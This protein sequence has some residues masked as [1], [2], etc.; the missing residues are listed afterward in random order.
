[1][2][3]EPSY[4]I[5]HDRDY[6]RGGGDKRE[7]SWRRRERKPRERMRRERD[8][9]ERLD[10]GPEE[11]NGGSPS[12]RTPFIIAKKDSGG[13][14]GGSDIAAKR[15]SPVVSIQRRVF[16]HA[17]SSSNSKLYTE[18]VTSYQKH[19]GSSGGEKINEATSPSPATPTAAPVPNE[20]PPTGLAALKIAPEVFPTESSSLIDGAFQWSDKIFETLLDQ[21]DFIVVGCVGMQAAG[22]STLMSMISGQPIDTI[23]KTRLVFRPQKRSD[24][25][26]CIHRTVGVD[27]YVTSGRMILLDTQPLLSPSM[28]DQYLRYDRKVPSEYST[29]EI[30]LEIQA[31]QILTFLYTVCHVVLVVQDHFTDLNLLNLLKTAEMLKP[32]TVSHAGQDGSGLGTSPEDYTEYFPY[33]VFVY[34]CCGP[35]M[36]ELH[37]LHSICETTAKIFESSRLRIRNSASVIRASLLTYT[38]L[39][40]ALTDYK[41]LNIFLLPSIQAVSSMEDDSPNASRRFRGNPILSVL[42]RQLR[43][44]LAGMPREL[45]THNVL[46]E[47]NWFHYAAR[48]WEAVKKSNLISEYHRLLT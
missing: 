7:R 29:A 21:N 14:G 35:H 1:M 5:D 27:M 44:Q 6:K 41:D 28:L 24:L 18:S 13:G 9:P 3:T 36:F 19:R 31:L 40:D 15:E 42:V 38:E 46:S 32:S 20:Q 10:V 33:V 22:K 30:C 39:S 37:I 17:G 47:R 4:S 12:M 48:T 43:H 45:F 8:R 16:D 26:K 34:T 23:E 2:E 25:E 11:E